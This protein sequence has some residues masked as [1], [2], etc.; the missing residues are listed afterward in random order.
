MSEHPEAYDYI[1]VGAGSA[2]CVVAARLSEDT[3]SEVL[4]LEAGGPADHPDVADPTKWPTLFPGALDWGY[5]TVPQRHLN[6]RVVPV[7]RAKM[8]GGCNSHNA[9]AW[10]HGHPTDYDDWANAGNTGWDYKSILPLLKRVESFTGPASEHRGTSGPIHVQLPDCSNPIGAAFIEAGV[11]IGLP[12]FIDHNAGTMEGIGFFNFTIKDGQR[13]S[14]VHA[15][16]QPALKRARIRALTHAHTRRLLFEGSRCVGVEYIKDG[17]IVSAR[18]SIEVVVCAGAIGSPHVLLASGVGPADELRRVGIDVVVDVP[19]VGK[20]LHD[21]PLLAGINYEAPERELPPLC[22]NGAE[23]TLWWKS[24]PDLRSPDIQPVI[25]EFPF[26]TPELAGR[27]ADPVPANCWAIAPSVVRPASRGHVKL[28]SSD[29]MVLPEIDM[30]YLSE[31]ADTRALCQAIELCR[32]IGNARALSPW[33]KREITPGPRD[34]AK[35]IDFVRESTWTYFHP[36]GSCRMGIDSMAV[37]DP[38]LKVRGVEGLRVADASIMPAVTTG[39][40]NAP[41]VLIGEKAAEM[42]RAARSRHAT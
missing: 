1:V 39:N 20:N 10:V 28:R 27:M 7:P 17:R 18:A 24:S 21:H 37:V 3:G 30:G 34:R 25:I 11:E 4:L 19:G 8:L 15:F 29:P 31:E 2:G 22:N 9:N 26:F 16:L 12:R 38:E 35:M 40:T 14:V 23:S 13:F 32:E 5:E 41:S 6:G 42:I 36:A 33:R